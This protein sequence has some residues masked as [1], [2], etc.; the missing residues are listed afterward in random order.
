MCTAAA[1]STALQPTHC[2]AQ[3][4]AQHAACATHNHG[5]PGAAVLLLL[6]LLSHPC[7]LNCPPPLRRVSGLPPRQRVASLAAA[8]KHS[9]AVMSGGGLY[10]WG[11]NASGQLGYGTSDSGSNPAP[12]MV[13]ALS[14]R[15]MA[16]VAAAKHHTGGCGSEC[17]AVVYVLWVCCGGSKLGPQAAVTTATLQRPAAP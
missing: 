3:H 5:K 1:T 12:R 16:A 14:G 15:S 13:E 2:L 9:A 11:C 10:T 8:N 6:Q 4:A 17:G 7:L